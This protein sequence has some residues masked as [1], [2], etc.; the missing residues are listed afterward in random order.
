MVQIWLALKQ[1]K[2]NQ[3]GLCGY[4]RVHPTSLVY[5]SPSEKRELLSGSKAIFL[6]EKG[7]MVPWVRMS[8]SLYSEKP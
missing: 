7:N 5:F 4:S 6:K 8:G 2:F 3:V 1:N